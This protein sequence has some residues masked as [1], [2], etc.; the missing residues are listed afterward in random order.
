[1]CEPARGAAAVVPIAVN[2]S[3]QS[4]P[5]VHPIHDSF[6]GCD[7]E[8]GLESVV[9]QPVGAYDNGAVLEAMLRGVEVERTVAV[10]FPARSGMLTRSP[11]QENTSLRV[12]KLHMSQSSALSVQGELAH[13]SSEGTLNSVCL[14]FS[15]QY[16]L[17]T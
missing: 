11:V 6:A 13:A 8:T 9:R 3:G 4:F 16:R 7:V 5:G 10:V 12:F 2:H 17:I 15:F 1:M 14:N